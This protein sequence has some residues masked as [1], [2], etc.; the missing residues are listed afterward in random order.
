MITQYEAGSITVLSNSTTVTG[1]GTRWL[2][3][4]SPGD[5]ITI[6]GETIEIASVDDFN[7]L[8]LAAD[9]TG[10]DATLSPYIITFTANL[11]R[12]KKQKRQVIFEAYR[13]E[14]T[15]I[16]ANYEQS[17]IDTWPKQET[18]ARA[19]ISDNQASVPFLSNQAAARG[20]TVAALA[21]IIVTKADVYEA[22]IATALGKR[23]KL[24]D[25]INASITTTELNAINW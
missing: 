11:N 16:T 6:N 23:Q 13:D 3:Y 17:E 20:I 1:H 12:L 22:D 9:Y 18:Q 2:T 19:Y 24:I 5:D 10:M 25:E 7:Q 15:I 14:V 8:T 21:N 4:V